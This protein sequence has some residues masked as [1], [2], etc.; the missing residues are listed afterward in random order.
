VY[1][2]LI[3]DTHRLLFRTR[4]MPH[5]NSGIAY[6]TDAHR[7]SPDHQNLLKA[8]DFRQI[9]FRTHAH[10]TDSPN[11]KNFRSLPPSKSLEIRQIV[12]MEGLG[13][14]DAVNL[15]AVVDQQ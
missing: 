14:R 11:Y 10:L 13:A 8:A 15:R 3:G 9:I 4:I 1:F 5:Q 7:F 2:E 6:L 12:A